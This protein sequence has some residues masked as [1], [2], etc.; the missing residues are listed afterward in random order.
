VTGRPTS[1][2]RVVRRDVAFD[3]TSGAP[4]R[5]RLLDAALKKLRHWRN[6]SVSAVR[7]C[8]RPA[9]TA[10]AQDHGEA[11]GPERRGTGTWRRTWVMV[12][13]A[14]SFGRGAR[15]KCEKS[16]SAP[17]SAS[18][19]WRARSARE[20][21]EEAR[22]AVAEERER[23]PASAPPPLAKQRHHE[24]VG[25]LLARALVSRRALALYEADG[26]REIVESL[27]SPRGEHSSTPPRGGP[28]A[29]RDPSRSIARRPRRVGRRRSPSASRRRR[30]GIRRPTGA[31][32]ATVEERVQAT[33]QPAPLGQSHTRRRAQT[34]RH[35][36]RL[37]SP[38]R[39]SVPPE[40]WRRRS[41]A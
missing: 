15:S 31:R 18:V 12:A 2:A 22:V 16:A 37:V 33:G 40:S 28:S 17:E 5:E 41:S 21:E 25:D 36:A 9:F 29:C 30:A 13:N 39:C 11:L 35:V 4:R 10:L 6:F 1:R 20:V 24:L 23:F 8:E 14:A 7:S 19:S 32:V 3:G 27:P 38:T 34:R 26:R